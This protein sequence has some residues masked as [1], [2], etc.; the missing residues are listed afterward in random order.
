MPGR[1]IT[2]DAARDLVFVPTGSPSPDFFGGLRPG[3]NAHANSV[4][5]L[6]GSTGELVWSFQTVHHDLWDYDIAAQPVL[7]DVPR[8]GRE[9]AAVPQPTKM[10]SLFVLDRETGQAAL[11]RRGAGRAEERRRRGDRARPRSRPRRS[12]RC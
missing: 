9:V 1:S 2:V 3:D 6:R 12:C 10:G 8:D 7:V 4:V 11:R 5:A